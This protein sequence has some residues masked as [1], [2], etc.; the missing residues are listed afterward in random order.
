MMA[1]MLQVQSPGDF[2]CSLQLGLPGRDRS[3]KLT[4]MLD[5]MQLITDLFLHGRKQLMQLLREAFQLMM[6]QYG[7]HD[8]D[9]R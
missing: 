3:K 2:K 9:L 5:I 7:R 6:I 4:H 8:D 1:Q